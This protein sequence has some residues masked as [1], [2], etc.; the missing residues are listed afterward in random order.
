MDLNDQLIFLKCEILRIIR[1]LTHC[2]SFVQLPNTHF[3]LELF[4]TV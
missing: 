2:R 1:Q 3:E 4:A